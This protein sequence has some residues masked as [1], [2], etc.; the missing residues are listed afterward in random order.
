VLPQGGLAGQ[1][2]CGSAVPLVTAVQ[3]PAPLRLQ[4]WHVPHTELAQHAPS[5]QLLLL[6]S[7]PT[8]QVA[9]FAFLPTHAVPEQ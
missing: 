4:A 2:P 6:H 5:T 9:P 8:E 3:V 1:S 7:L